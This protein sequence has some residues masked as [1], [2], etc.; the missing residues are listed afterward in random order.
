MKTFLI[1]LGLFV[2]Q[3]NTLQDRPVVRLHPHEDSIPSEYGGD[4]VELMKAPPVVQLP[5]LPPVHDSHGRPW[6]IEV[7]NLG[8]GTVTIEGKA[9]FHVQVPAGN[10][11]TIKSTNVGYSSVR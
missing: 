3:Y 11:V 6:S 9:Q 1:Y 2:G 4:L 8:P 5:P 7:R 10:T